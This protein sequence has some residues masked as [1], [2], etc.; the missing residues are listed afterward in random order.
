[1]TMK[2]NPRPRWFSTAA[3][4]AV[5]ALAAAM[6]TAPVAAH[7]RWD[8][9]GSSPGESN[10]AVYIIG[11]RVVAIRRDRVPPGAYGGHGVDYSPNLAAWILDS[12]CAGRGPARTR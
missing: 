3:V 6:L 11:D 5:I 10:P 12:G 9:T 2:P 8:E 4:G 1:M 7:P